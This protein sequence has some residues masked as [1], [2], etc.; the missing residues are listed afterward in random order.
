MRTTLAENAANYPHEIRK[1]EMLGAKS[2]LE[3]IRGPQGLQIQVPHVP[4][5]KYAY[6]FRILSSYST[7]S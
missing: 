1:V 5:C 2:Q 4:P 3:C 7:Q 6:S